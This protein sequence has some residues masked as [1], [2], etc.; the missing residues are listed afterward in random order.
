MIDPNTLYKRFLLKINKNDTNTNVKVSKGVFVIIYNEQQR[1]YVNATI[2]KDESSKLIDDISE[3][4]VLDKQLKKVADYSNKTDFTLPDK[5]AKRTSLNILASKG[6]CKNNP[7]VVWFIKPLNIDVILQNN[8]QSP[9]FEYQET[10]GIINGSN[11][12]IYKTD[13]SINNAYLSYYFYPSDIDIEGYINILGKSSTN[14]STELVS[15]NT[16]KILDRCV[17]EVS[18]NYEDV[19]RMQMALQRQQLNEK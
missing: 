19:Q 8:N 11:I 18:Q 13:F 15:Q 12:S 17:V 1:K 6:E 14:I 5:F 7:M 3:L 10:V 16:D 2:E 9:S 4:L